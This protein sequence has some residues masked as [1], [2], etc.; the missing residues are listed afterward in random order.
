MRSI[1]GGLVA[2]FVILWAFLAFF[3]LGGKRLVAVNAAIICLG[4]CREEAE[5]A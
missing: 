2:W 5:P 1:G 4:L 3:R